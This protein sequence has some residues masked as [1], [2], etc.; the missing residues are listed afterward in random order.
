M[1]FRAVD[2]LGSEALDL[3]GAKL[4]LQFRLDK[5]LIKAR[6]LLTRRPQRTEE[7]VEFAF[8]I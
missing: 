8:A 6:T 7:V 3:V 2:K 5:G 4:L 1:G